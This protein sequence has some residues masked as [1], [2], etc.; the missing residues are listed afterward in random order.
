PAVGAAGVHNGT[1]VHD[2]VERVTAGEVDPGRLDIVPGRRGAEARHR[3]ADAGPVDFQGTGGGDDEG[4]AVRGQ[5]DA[6]DIGGEHAGG[7]QDG[8][9]PA[10]QRRDRAEPAA[11]VDQRD[12]RD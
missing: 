8:G 1:G 5:G 7:G 2:R 3:V 4:G 11:R 10:S 12:T 6:P 9:R